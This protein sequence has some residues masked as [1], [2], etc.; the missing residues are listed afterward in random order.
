MRL[1][2]FERIPENRG[3]ERNRHGKNE[4]EREI[5]LKSTL[6]YLGKIGGE[7]FQFWCGFQILLSGDKGISGFRKKSNR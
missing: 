1:K 6:N 4:R 2:L 5:F 7:I 3:R